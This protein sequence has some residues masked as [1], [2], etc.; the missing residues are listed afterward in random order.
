MMEGLTSK[1]GQANVGLLGSQN[2]VR[3]E[4]CRNSHSHMAMQAE[5]L[6]CLAA[7]GL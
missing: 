1:L 5:V 6:G 3:H 7:A 2:H 4:T